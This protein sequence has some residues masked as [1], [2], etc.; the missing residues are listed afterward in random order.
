M[1][2][3]LNTYL[4][5]TKAYSSCVWDRGNL[6]NP[7]KL[8]VFKYS[9]SSLSKAY[10][11]SKVIIY[12]SLHE[13]YKSREKDL[14]D[15]IKNEFGSVK[16]DIDVVIRNT[17]NEY[18]SQWK[19]TYDL[20]DDDLVFYCGNHDHIFVGNEHLFGLAIEEFR[21]QL[22]A[23][24]GLVSLRFSH[25]PEMFRAGVFQ[26]CQDDNRYPLPTNIHKT[27]ICNSDAIQI[28]SKDLYHKWF[29]HN[30]TD[31]LMGRTDGPDTHLSENIW[32][33]KFGWTV[34]AMNHEHIRHFDGY[35][36]VE[37]PNC[38]C[39]A[40]DI[41]EGYFDNNIVVRIGYDDRIDGTFKINPFQEKSLA[42]D[43]NGVDFPYHLED[44]PQHI[45]SRVSDIDINPSFHTNDNKIN[46]QLYLN[47]LGFVYRSCLKPYGGEHNLLN[48]VGIRRHDLNHYI[49]Y[50]GVREN[51]LSGLSILDKHINYY[52][53]RYDIEGTNN[54]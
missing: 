13:E 19:E 16:D 27:L 36:H 3:F 12:F 51:G 30:D 26:H 44:L 35:N 52:Y 32:T 49:D 31:R 41:P 15:Y 4:V 9:I 20:L 42:E 17:R 33:P 2:L 47:R 38:S 45:R 40:L 39:P 37:I 29:W 53:K 34:Y 22:S 23:N 8:D 10:P 28:L 48:R 6:N 46:K 5:P 24:E 21:S 54:N 7:C 1:I 14:I 18:Q 25:F 43:A 50:D 11:W